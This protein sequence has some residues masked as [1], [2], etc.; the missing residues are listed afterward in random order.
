MEQAAK[1]LLGIEDLNKCIQESARLVIYG[2]G[3]FGKRV[4]D[5][6]VSIKEENKIE[7]IVVTGKSTDCAYKG[8]EIHTAA[9]FLPECGDCYVLIAASSIYK[10]EMAEVI[11]RYN[12]QYRYI[13][14]ELYMDLAVAMD[15]RALVSYSG[16]DFLCAGFFKCGTTSLHSALKLMDRIYLSA[17][18]ESGFF[19]WCD[20]VK[21]AKEVLIDKVFNNIREGQSVGMIEP[22]FA[23]CAR[24]VYDFFGDS[25]KIFFL[26]RNPVNAAFSGFK[27]NNREGMPGMEAAYRGAG[28][29]FDIRIFDEWIEQSR[30][31]DTLSDWEYV[32][33]IEQFSEL[34]PKAQMKIVIFEELIRNPQVILNEILDFIGI[35]E[36]YEFEK[37]PLANE[38]D[39][40]MA[41]L[42]G[43]KLG[44]MIHDWYFAEYSLS[45]EELRK[46]RYENYGEYTEIKENY[47]KA[48][49]LYGVKMTTEQKRILEKYYAGSVRKLESFI[50][51]DLS[52]LWF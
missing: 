15:R 33:W 51:R 31:E 40:V 26:V 43:Y 5:Y 44:K 20:E 13:S 4:I 12:K 9:S 42:E 6:I 46:R 30:C 8:I 2:A 18:K 3:D 41:D 28:G 22:S 39:F 24:R 38:G 36:K 34:Y 50:G 27:M 48:E 25:V 47:K 29:K 52:E 35:S 19:Q 10:Q 16:V 1:Y 17:V 11:R 49:K 32:R 45:E 21:N 23:Y 14:D 7:G 37:L